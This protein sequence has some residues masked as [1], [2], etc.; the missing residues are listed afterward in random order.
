MFPVS[1]AFIVR[2][3][4]KQT[5]FSLFLKRPC[6]WA[7]HSCLV[8]C[9]NVTVLLFCSRLFS[10]PLSQLFVPL[11]VPFF[12]SRWSGGC[13]FPNTFQPA[14]LGLY[15][16]GVLAPFVIAPSAHRYHASISIQYRPACGSDRHGGLK[17]K[18]VLIDSVW[19][20]RCPYGRLWEALLVLD[21]CLHQCFCVTMHSV[22]VHDESVSHVSTIPPCWPFVFRYNGDILSFHMSRKKNQIFVLSLVDHVSISPPTLM[23]QQSFWKQKIIAIQISTSVVWPVWHLDHLT[24]VNVASLCGENVNLS[25][26]LP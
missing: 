15:C 8:K 26:T 5:C 17:S 22:P 12:C 23:F 25:L 4:E 7:S 3:K 11:A 1:L 10:S 14:Y 21:L 2:L 18:T 9:P 19:V 24:L 16:S 13:L 20:W 6:K